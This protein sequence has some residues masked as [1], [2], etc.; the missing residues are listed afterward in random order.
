MNSSSACCRTATHSAPCIRDEHG[1][2]LCVGLEALAF[3]LSRG[4]QRGSLFRGVGYEPFGFSASGLEQLSGLRAKRL[5][6]GASLRTHVLGI[7]DGFRGNGLHGLVRVE[8]RL[9]EH[10][11]GP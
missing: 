5:S 7:R 8:H 1:R 4:Y 9:A 3:A 2:P 10:A 6:F 11:F